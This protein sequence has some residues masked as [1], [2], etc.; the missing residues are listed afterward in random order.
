MEK[1]QQTICLPA[2]RQRP[3]QLPRHIRLAPHLTNDEL[4]DRY[5][6]AN[7]PVER[8]HW[9]FLWWLAGGMTATAV[10]A[11]A[12]YSIYWIGQI[13]RRYNT[14]R[15]DIMLRHSPQLSTRTQSTTDH[16][17]P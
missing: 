16:R 13:A 6:R 3:T 17:H 4:H 14:D 15:P 12:G 2:P 9:H 8:S 1:D 11:V 7:D 10:A 5:H